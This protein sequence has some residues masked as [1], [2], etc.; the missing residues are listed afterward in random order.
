MK[1]DDVRKIFPEASDDQ[2]DAI[3]NGVGAELNPLKAQLEDAT[4][5]LGDA[6]NSLASLRAS[7]A[8]LKSQL[9]EANGKLREGMTAEELLAQREKAAAEKERDFTLKSNALD[10]KAI[11]VGAGFDA[12]DIEAL[13]PR[14]VSEDK[15]ATEA[16]AKALVDFDSKRRAKVE[17]A[18]K[19][20]LLKANPRLQGGG[21]G[22]SISKRDFDALPFDEQMKLVEE[23]PGILKDLK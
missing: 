4:G 18:T 21:S 1:R 12:E 14:V 9:E 8:A 16:A 15:E 22:T 11:F 7:E 19:D 3:L 23:T 10:A 6:T 20:E 2:V 17:Q 13:L 5:K